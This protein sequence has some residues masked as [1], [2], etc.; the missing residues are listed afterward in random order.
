MEDVYAKQVYYAMALDPLH[1]GSGGYRLGRVDMSITREPGT[2]LPKIP[3]TSLAGVSRAYTALKTGRYT[4][5]KQNTQYSCAGKGGDGGEKHCGDSDCPVCVTYGF[6]KGKSNSSFQ[7]LAQFSDARILFFPVR[8]MKGPVWITCPSV[9]REF[10]EAAKE[11]KSV[12]DIKPNFKMDENKDEIQCKVDVGIKA[13][14]LG[15]LLLNIGNR[16]Q[17][18]IGTLTG[19][20]LNNIL[21]GLVLV[22]DRLFPR[23]VNDNLEV[24]TSVAIDP[25]TGAA[26]E[27]ALYS[28]EALPRTTVLWFE[29]IFNNP[30]H[31]RVGKQENAVES[32]QKPE[33]Q[34]FEW[35][36][37]NVESGLDLIEHLGIG[38]MGTRGMGR[39]KVLNLDGSQNGTGSGS[40]SDTPVSADSKV[41]AGADSTVQPQGVEKK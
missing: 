15:W 32:S 33:Q 14:N 40:A 6:S 24:R 17:P 21:P 4:W 13:L 7:G 38:G 26:E 27:G 5:S 34:T 16:E 39:M 36:R 20:H 9:I 22:P 31:Y 23:I 2:N 12:I 25:V 35:L 29:V 19:E 11:N 37:Q 3:G 41:K 1:P 8:S 30:K 18:I 28:Y 10:I